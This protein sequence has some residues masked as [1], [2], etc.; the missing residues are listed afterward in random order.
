MVSE[1]DILLRAASL[2]DWIRRVVVWLVGKRRGHLLSRTRSGGVSVWQLWQKCADLIDMRSSWSEALR[3]NDL[4]AVIHP[5]MP[6]PAFKHGLG[7]AMTSACSYLFLANMLMWPSGTV[8]VATIRPEEAHYHDPIEKDEISE[9]AAEIMEGSEGLPISVCV[10][11]SA[12]QDETCLRV[13]RDIERE[14]KFS[15]QPKTYCL[16]EI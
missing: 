1:Y 4:D 8:P 13:M 6:L 12:Y 9:L 3:E 2:P 10:M 15:A 11:S 16:Q 7:G 5:A 14:V